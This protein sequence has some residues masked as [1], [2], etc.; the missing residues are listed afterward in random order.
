MPKASDLLKK[1]KSMKTLPGIA[2]SLIRLIS[3]NTSNL[4][5]FEDI[6]RLDPTLAL[7]LLKIVNSPHYGLASH[8]DNITEA[9]TFI[10]MENLRN[11]IVMDVLKHIIRSGPSSGT[12]FSRTALWRHSA[13]VAVISQA[14]CE[15]IHE[16]K[17]ENAFLCGLLHDI[18]LIL[19]D[20]LEPSRFLNAFEAYR[21]GDSDPISFY[22][23]QEIGTDHTLVGQQI[24]RDWHLPVEIQAA[25]RDHHNTQ[26]VISPQSLTGVLQITEYFA[27]RMRLAPFPEAKIQLPTPLVSHIHSHI[28]EYKTLASDLPGLI[29]TADK[30]LGLETT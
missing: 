26:K 11:L 8:V 4:R 25:I 7:R 24:A 30:V 1:M 29:K 14:I 22:E 19:E 27:D 9:V 2:V 3:D 17:G 15:R 6:I 5:E 20:Q 13:A 12:G 23:N 21:A 10:G 16:I 18:G 28:N